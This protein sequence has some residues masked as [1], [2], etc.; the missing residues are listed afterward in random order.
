MDGPE[1]PIEVRVPDARPPAQ[2]LLGA[3]RERLGEPR[4]V[5]LR[6]LA[7]DL[8]L[9]R[10]VLARLF[11]AA[12]RT[13]DGERYG[14]SDRAYARD[15][16]VLLERFDVDVVERMLR[17][18]QRAMTTVA[19][20][21]LAQLQGD[22]RLAPLLDPEGDL[23]ADLIEA[24]VE[25]AAR[26]L[27]VTQ[28][29]IAGDHNEALLR[30]LDTSVVADASTSAAESVDLAVAF[31]DLVGFT[32]LSA[33]ADPTIVGDVLGGFE[34]GV[35]T[36]A[37]DVGD[38]LVVKFIGD[39]AMLVGGVVDDLVEVCLR[40]VE[41][42]LPSGDEVERRAGVAAGG[43]Q[44]RDGDYVGHPVNTAARLTDLARP[45]S[46]L[47]DEPAVERLDDEA[48]RCKRLHGRKLKGLGRMR[49]SRVLRPDDD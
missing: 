31:I 33:T 42:P 17:L 22:P 45:G 38:V 19:V 34:D 26:L 48:W 37:N 46:V 29:L 4:E 2:R 47:V 21:Q 15:L 30:L 3:V 13:R 5:P 27:P 32:R 14:A 49:P 23:D 25:D 6:D 11:A 40:V 35:H 41:D 44:I 43:V 24:L 16:S 36:A 7:F 1:R 12:G 18:H 10:D 39:A 28:R 20:N 8:R 9:D